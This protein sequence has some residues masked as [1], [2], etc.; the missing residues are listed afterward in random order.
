[1]CRYSTPRLRSDSSSLSYPP[2]ENTPPP[3]I[4][5]R[6][7]LAG[8]SDRTRP[9]WTAGRIAAGIPAAPGLA[10]AFAGQP[11]AWPLLISAALIVL[12][13]ETLNAAVSI[14][15]SRQQTRR[16]EI[17]Y[18]STVMLSAALARCIDDTHA[19][20]QNLSGAREAEEAA[21][22]RDSARQLVTAWHSQGRPHE[23]RVSR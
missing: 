13:T 14:H 11:A 4:P 5:A 2:G 23:P 6:R 18:H 3:W 9:R 16:L 20:A 7:D 15:A 21:Q 12:V 8:R 10:L 1:M 17:T 19:R 22:V